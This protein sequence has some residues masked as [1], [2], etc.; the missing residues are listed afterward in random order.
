MWHMA[1]AWR[2][3]SRV[4]LSPTVRE[5]SRIEGVGEV[6]GVVTPKEVVVMVVAAAAAAAAAAV[7]EAEAVGA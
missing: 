3:L 4:R 6:L 1:G 5:C 2:L 7:A